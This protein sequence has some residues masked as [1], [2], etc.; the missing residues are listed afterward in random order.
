M[1]LKKSKS[2]KAKQK[3]KQRKAMKTVLLTPYSMLFVNEKQ[4]KKEQKII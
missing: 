1:V 4:Q 3:L 2:T